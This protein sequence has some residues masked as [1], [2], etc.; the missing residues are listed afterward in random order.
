LCNKGIIP[1]YVWKRLPVETTLSLL[2]PDGNS[3]LYATTY[4]DA[5]GRALFW[6][7]LSGFE[8]STVKVFYHLAKK[9]NLVFDIG[10]NTGVFT[11][12]AASANQNLEV[13]SFE[14]VPHIFNKLSKNIKINELEDRCH[15]HQMA[16]SNFNGFGK[17]HVP[18]GDCPSSASLDINGFRGAKGYLINVSVRKLD[19]LCLDFK[20]VDL[21][22]VD[23]EGYEDK[24][25][26]GMENILKQSR[27]KIIVECN[28]DGPYKVVEGILNSFNYKFYHL[29]KN[30][31]KLVE[32]IIP[33][34]MQ[35][36][37]NFLCIC[38]KENVH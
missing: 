27:P 38:E 32:K 15:A 6:R 34:K 24:V 4:N 30:G 13:V 36:H 17:F 37:R 26:E 8:P 35:L 10:A 3:F 18:F 9:S 31:P 20:K 29:L 7:Q 2:L 25:L 19:D 21:V 23:V 33:C 14:P 22:K 12:L 28:I 16:V 11:L 5:I 1:K